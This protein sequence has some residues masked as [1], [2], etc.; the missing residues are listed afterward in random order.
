MEND[1]NIFNGPH[2]EVWSEILVAEPPWA[3]CVFIG[4][5]TAIVDTNKFIAVQKA[6][7]FLAIM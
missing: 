3:I 7:A 1:R 6:F 5:Y 2:K 4:F